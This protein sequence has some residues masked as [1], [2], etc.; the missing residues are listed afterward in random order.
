MGFAK[1]AG[2]FEMLVIGRFSA[3]IASGFFTGLVP[4]YISEIAPVRIR[5]E[6]GTLNQELYIASIIISFSFKNDNIYYYLF[7][8]LVLNLTPY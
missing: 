6:L 1:S 7:S 8:W 2:S 4:L 3:G 5:G